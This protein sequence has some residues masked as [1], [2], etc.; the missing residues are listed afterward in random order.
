M[1]D[2]D[3]VEVL[4]GITSFVAPSEFVAWSEELL[5]AAAAAAV[6]VGVASVL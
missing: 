4:I 5:A 3:V 1:R 6:V 2:R